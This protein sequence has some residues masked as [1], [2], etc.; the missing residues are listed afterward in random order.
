MILNNLI[1]NL[2][3]RKIKICENN[4]LKIHP[5][6]W[7]YANFT[8]NLFGII[9]QVFW[10]LLLICYYALTTWTWN[11]SCI[12]RFSQFTERQRWSPGLKGSPRGHFPTKTRTYSQCHMNPSAHP[13]LCHWEKVCSVPVHDPKH[14]QQQMIRSMLKKKESSSQVW[15]LVLF[16]Y[17]CKTAALFCH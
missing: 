16:F 8:S 7:F 14:P 1:E 2:R 12:Q 17:I 9:V 13:G 15:T 6:C 10:S 5:N 4:L 11:L 3:Y